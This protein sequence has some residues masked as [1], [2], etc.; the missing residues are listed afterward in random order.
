LK[1]LSANAF[2]SCFWQNC[3][4]INFNELQLNI[5]SFVVGHRV[6]SG[7]NVFRSNRFQKENRRIIKE[8]SLSISISRFVYQLDNFCTGNYSNSW[9]ISFLILSYTF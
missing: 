6:C 3:R 4:H 7:Y 5:P 8:L 9:V 2:A 1:H